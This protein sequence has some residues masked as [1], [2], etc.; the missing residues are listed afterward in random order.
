MRPLHPL[1]ILAC[2]CA[3]IPSAVR[4]TPA[5]PPAP[6][7][8]TR[9]ASATS[10]NDAVQAFTA[11]AE[12]LRQCILVDGEVSTDE[13]LAA[14]SAD[15][16]RKEI[17]VQ[18]KRQAFAAHL[19][20]DFAEQ[21]GVLLLRR[22]YTTFDALP[23]IPYE[24]TREICLAIGQLLSPYDTRAIFN[25][26]KR[27]DG[28]YASRFIRAIP[29][30]DRAVYREGVLLSS[31]PAAQQ[32]Q[33]R[34]LTRFAYFDSYIKK[35]G[36]TQDDV[37]GSE[38]AAAFFALRPLPSRNFPVFG[39][40]Y[41]APQGQQIWRPLSSPTAVYVR[42]SYP[43]SPLWGYDS[44][45][46]DSDGD[47]LAATT[48][49][50]AVA[51]QYLPTLTLKDLGEK[52]SRHDGSQEFAPLKRIERRKVTVVGLSYAPSL[53]VARAS[54]AL[55]GARLAH[56]DDQPKN[57][58]YQIVLPL[59]HPRTL[60]E[61][62]QAMHDMIPASL[63]RTLDAKLP[64]IP[65][66]GNRP[67]PAMMRDERKRAQDA[68]RTTLLRAA[69]VKRL[70]QEVEPRLSPGE[71]T[72]PL[73]QAG[74]TARDLLALLMLVDM[75]D[76]SRSFSADGIPEYITNYDKLYLSCGTMKDSQGRP[77]VYQDGSYTFEMIFGRD[78]ATIR[79]A[80]S[81]LM[82]FPIAKPLD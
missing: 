27:E 14:L 31:L 76:T 7:P 36:T 43:Y 5:P 58:R 55:Y 64:D 75:M 57:N 45:G 12:S 21:D 1:S 33:C 34:L 73:A 61:E 56:I 26:L 44:G 29:D 60:D 63:W 6:R 52:I 30:A 25:P 51:K 50:D 15:D 69:I 79:H 72:L 68:T 49:P 62:R 28:T 77:I 53:H 78:K 54:A 8:S 18:K 19:D 22:K 42:D 48:V 16:V 65:L 2:A 4:A 82:R 46:K 66:P 38:R 20:C 32:E 80:A 24:E 67:E 40:V 81:M 11:F 13:I 39:W 9:P 37:D 47:A 70:R 35:H 17:D 10:K 71:R 41:P 74:E 59:P 3:L 23:S